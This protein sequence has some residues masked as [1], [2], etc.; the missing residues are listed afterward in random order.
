[1]EFAAGEKVTL[2][3]GE[4]R[5]FAEVEVNGQQVGVRLWPPYRFDITGALKKGNN[6]LRI[7]VTNTRANEL[8]DEKLSS[9]LIGPVRLLVS[10]P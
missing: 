2:D 3:L 1:V 10:R 9:G 7:G 6:R 8:T 5:E 4:V